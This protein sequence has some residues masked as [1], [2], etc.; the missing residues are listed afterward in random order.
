VE[1]RRYREHGARVHYWDWEAV[2]YRAPLLDMS[3]TR[4]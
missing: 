3:G 1:T 4:I 2:G